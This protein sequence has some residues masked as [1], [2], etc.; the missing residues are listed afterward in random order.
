MSDRPPRSVG[1]I[2]NA[3][4]LTKPSDMRAPSGARASAPTAPLAKSPPLDRHVPPCM[5][6]AFAPG[7]AVQLAEDQRYADKVLVRRGER[8]RV[9]HPSSQAASWVVSFPMMGPKLRVV[10]ERLLRRTD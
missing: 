1:A 8:G 7:D 2:T 9:M 10:P 5:K 6:I 4:A 3:S